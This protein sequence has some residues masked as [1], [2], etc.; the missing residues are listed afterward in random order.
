MFVTRFFCTVCACN[1]SFSSEVSKS[2]VTAKY[3][4]QASIYRQVIVCVFMTMSVKEILKIWSRWVAFGK[5][6]EGHAESKWLPGHS[7]LAPFS[8]IP[9]RI[10]K[11]TTHLHPQFSVPVFS[12]SITAHS[13]NIVYQTSC[14]SYTSSDFSTFV[15]LLTSLS[16]PC[17]S[18][19]PA[20]FQTSFH[21]CLIPKTGTRSTTSVFCRDLHSH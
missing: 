4:R 16:F 1:K 21:K 11:K 19:S 15:V 7:L 9:Q 18:S 17:Y 12:P 13:D 20:A 3:R 10:L 8:Q 2:T 14:S 5:K 6:Q